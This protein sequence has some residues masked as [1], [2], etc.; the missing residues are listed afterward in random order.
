MKTYQEMWL[1][2]ALSGTSAY[3]KADEKAIPPKVIGRKEES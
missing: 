2:L 1:M 3:V